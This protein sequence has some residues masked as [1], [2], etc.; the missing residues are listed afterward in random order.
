MLVRKVDAIIFLGQKSLPLRGHRELLVGDSVN[1]LH[2][3]FIELLKLLS[4]YDV[5]L[6]QHLYT[7]LIQTVIHT[8]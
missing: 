2:G 3:N 5:P 6:Q 8:E 7:K 4:H 1:T